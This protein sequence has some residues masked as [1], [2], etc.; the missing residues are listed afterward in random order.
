M[1]IHRLK[2]A[3][4][5]SFGPDGVN[6]P[7]EPL[8]LLIGPN[9]SGKS[10]FLEAIALLQAAPRGISEPI[11]RVGGVREW[12]WKGS[13]APDSINIEAEV[14]YPQGGILRHS[15]TLADRNGRSEVTDEWIEPFKCRPGKGAGLSFYRPPQNRE[16]RVEMARANL[17]ATRFDDDEKTRTN[18]WSAPSMVGRHW[19]DAVHFAS[20]FCTDQSLLSVVANPQYPSLW[21]LKNQYARIRLYRNWSFG[22]SSPLRQPASAHVRSDYLNSDGTNLA[23]VLSNFPGENKRRLIK[24]L[25][26][27]YDGVVDLKFSVAGGTVALFLEEAGKREI[28]ATRLSDGTLRYLCLLAILLHHEPPSLVVIEEPELGLHPDLL[29]TVSDLLLA[30][31]K[32]SQLVITTHSDVLVDALT[33]TPESIVICEK[34]DAQTKM[35]RLGKEDLEKWLKDYRL[36]E[37]WTSGELGGNRW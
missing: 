7:L 26:R 11:S 4:L 1:L 14:D 15:L 36:G 30:A 21:H 20:E 19:E 33:N 31:S 9:G 12:L 22:P 25:Q 34:H 5:L 37:L 17:E 10:N 28:P 2:V 24:A 29:P 3:G 13:E 23:L 16:V 27:L 32:H 18:E 6:L 35:R 8:N